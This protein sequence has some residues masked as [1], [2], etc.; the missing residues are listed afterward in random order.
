MTFQ[1]KRKQRQRP[2]VP[3]AVA[4]NGLYRP[5]IPANELALPRECLEEEVQKPQKGGGD[6][7]KEGKQAL[8]GL[9]SYE[10][11]FFLLVI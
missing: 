2:R 7:G 10:D 9:I 8:S 5:T 11:T 6:R 1:R 4:P 3:K